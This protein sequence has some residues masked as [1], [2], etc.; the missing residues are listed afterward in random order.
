MGAMLTPWEATATEASVGVSG[1]ETFQPQLLRHETD[2]RFMRGAR[3]RVAGPQVA[4]RAP[5][6]DAAADHVARQVD[7]RQQDVPHALGLD[8]VEV[9]ERVAV[10][11]HGTPDVTALRQRLAVTVVLGGVVEQ[12]S[13]PRR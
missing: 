1:P 12:L 8:G 4:V 13:H 7:L 6:V 10:R 9:L 2:V 3:V 11:L 5:T